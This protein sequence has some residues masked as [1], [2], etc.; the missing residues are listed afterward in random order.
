ML[1]HYQE[2]ES[3]SLRQRLLSP[4]SLRRW[5]PAKFPYSSG[6]LR[7]DLLTARLSVSTEIA[8]SGPIFSEAPDSANLVRRSYPIEN[9]GFGDS[10]NV[11]NFEMLSLG[12]EKFLARPSRAHP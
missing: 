8:L 2:F 11:S 1:A 6:L 12:Q 7:E 9:A 3:L 5:S 4:T 10:V